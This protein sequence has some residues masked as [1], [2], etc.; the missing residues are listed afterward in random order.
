[1]SR[2]ALE[3]PLP[4]PYAIWWHCGDSPLNYHVLLCKVLN[5]KMTVFKTFCFEMLMKS[6]SVFWSQILLIQT[7]LFFLKALKV[8]KM[9]VTLFLNPSPLVCH[10]LFSQLKWTSLF[11]IYILKIFA[12]EPF[13]FGGRGRGRGGHGGGRG[14][15]GFGGGFGG[16]GG[17]RGRWG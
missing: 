3:K 14:R 4:S 13:L 7:W 17:G 16:F 8:W 1:M 6:K 2:G 10:V 5:L 9:Y 15:G 12:A 11:E